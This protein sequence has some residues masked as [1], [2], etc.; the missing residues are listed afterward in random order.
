VINYGP[1]SRE[2]KLMVICSVVTGSGTKA[3]FDEE[4][5]KHRINQCLTIAE[6]I[7]YSSPS[8]IAELA[9]FA[10]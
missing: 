5:L 10:N 3:H 7:I 6:E 9:D 4:E 8:R 2:E 1:L